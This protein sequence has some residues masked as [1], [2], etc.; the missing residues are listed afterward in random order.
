MKTL[1]IALI[2]AIFI[3]ITLASCSGGVSLAT[4]IPAPTSTQTPKPTATNTPKP[5]Q[6]PIPPTP[7]VAPPSML[8][9]YL[10]DVVVTNTDDFSSNTG[11]DL[12]AG[13]IFGGMLEIEGKDWNGLGKKGK[14]PEG[15]GIVIN[16]KYDKDAEFEVYYDY[17][18]WQTDAYRRFGI[19]YWNGSPK[20]NLW[21]GSR[22][23][24]FNNLHG[25]LKARS[26]TWYTLL[27]ATD[28]D[29]EFLAV[30]WNPENP[31]RTAIYHEKNEKWAGYD[32]D[33]RIGANKG[34]IV[35]DDF[36]EIEF[37][38]IKQ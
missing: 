18:A 38:A 26:D 33:L 10:D 6:T 14:F 23:L 15:T 30:I 35:F 37:S 5:T 20:A 31:E 19:Y 21:L 12:W 32:W 28:I 8:L 9:E 13:K 4:E 3:A 34:T 17:G 7:T 1:S 24:G 25:N 29:G 2:S 16:F 36:M 11:W 22:G 27:M